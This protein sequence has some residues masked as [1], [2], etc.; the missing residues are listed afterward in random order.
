MPKDVA[1]SEMTREKE[2]ILA[3]YRGM[4]LLWRLVLKQLGSF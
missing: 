2:Q 3:W 1:V 4:R